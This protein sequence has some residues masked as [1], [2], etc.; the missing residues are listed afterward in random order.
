L[1]LGR[2]LEMPFFFEKPDGLLGSPQISKKPEKDSWLNSASL[3]LGFGNA[4]FSGF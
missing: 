4:L 2:L 1:D 3:D